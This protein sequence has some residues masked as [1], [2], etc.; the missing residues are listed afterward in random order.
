MDEE[1]KTYRAKSEIDGFQSKTLQEAMTSGTILDLQLI[2]HDAQEHGQDEADLIRETSR[3]IKLDV[4]RQVDEQGARRLLR[5]GLD[6]V[7]GWED[8]EDDTK[9]LLVRLQSNEGQVKTV[10]VQVEDGDLDQVTQEA[11]ENSFVLNEKVSAFEVPLTQRYVDI[12]DDM[13]AKLIAKAIE[14]EGV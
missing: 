5:L 3:Q 1:E 9:E 7:R 14:L 10:Q 8:V 11:L 12:R 4:R 2:G 6:K 13:V